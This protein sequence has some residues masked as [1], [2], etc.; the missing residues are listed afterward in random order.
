LTLLGTQLTRAIKI[1]IAQ[2][3][4]GVYKR[5]RRGEFSVRKVVWGVGRMYKEEVVMTRGSG[6]G[7]SGSLDMGIVVKCGADLDSI[8]SVVVAL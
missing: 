8:R 1:I 5:R 4:I 7:S 6:G 3:I 2:R